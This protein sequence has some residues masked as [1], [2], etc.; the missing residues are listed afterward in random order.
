[1]LRSYHQNTTGGGGGGLEL[2]MRSDQK[3][4]EKDKKRRN[5]AGN[6]SIGTNSSVTIRDEI[7][8]HYGDE[9]IIKYLS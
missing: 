2:R 4:G 9:T 5:L 1:M 8:I 6:G 7:E 3:R